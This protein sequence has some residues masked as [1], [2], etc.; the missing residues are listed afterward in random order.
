MN[1]IPFSD[2][3]PPEKRSI[4][5]IPIPS[6]RRKILTTDQNFP[7]ASS[8]N[9]KPVTYPTQNPTATDSKISEI[10][11]PEKKSSEIYEYYYPKNI[12][13]DNVP[14][15]KKKQYI[16]GSAA[17]ILIFGFIFWIMTIFS[18]ATVVI[19]PK[20]QNIEVDMKITAT[21]ISEEGAVR[22]E[23]AKT[24][25]SNTVSVPATGEEAAELKA[26]GKV[27]IYNNYST[28]PQRLIIRTRLETKEGLIYRIPESVVVP[29]KTT[30]G[31]VETPGSIEVT[32]YA[33][34]AGEKYNIDK[35]DFTIP[36]FKSDAVR[37]KNFYARASTD[38]AGGF[39]GKMKTVSETEKQTALQKVDS[40]LKTELEKELQ[41]KVPDG[42]VLLS[43]SIIYETKELNKKE[44]GSSVIFGEEISAYGVMF[45]KKDLS[46]IITNE[47]I[48]KS[49]DWANIAS[50]IND[51]SSI[52]A[53]DLT[54]NLKTGDKAEIQIKGTAEVLADID[55]NVISQKL[56][57]VPKK[58]AAKLMNEFAGISSITAA[59]RPIWKNSFP[60]N[61]SKIYVQT[62]T[63][64]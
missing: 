39:I 59:I 63:N 51:F 4:R 10:K 62:A 2:V 31:G 56:L 53:A 47:Y 44:D 38:M 26:S 48:A 23:V 52:K 49:A 35:T 30:K 34:E 27:V 19:T 32:V 3:T 42:L 29:G 8:E 40:E 22:Y 7:Q 11:P 64:K 54:D 41:S 46:K 24:S 37:Y 60:S 15:S 50:N 1:K 13:G 61:S 21:N 14:K 28:E 55:L 20:N 17:L 5:N 36:G 25:K 33:D 9:Q 18:S 58:Q 43:G 57:G 6:N 45:D 12:S 16:F